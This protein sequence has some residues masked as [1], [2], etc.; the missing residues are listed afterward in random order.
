MQFHCSAGVKLCYNTQK[1]REL[2]AFP[3]S[4][5]KQSRLRSLRRLMWCWAAGSPSSTCGFQTSLDGST[6]AFN[7]RQRRTHTICV[8]LH[9]Q[10]DDAYE[11]THLEK[12]FVS[13]KTLGLLG[14]TRHGGIR[15]LLLLRLC[16][17]G[18]RVHPLYCQY[19][20]F[21]P[22]KCVYLRTCHVRRRSLL[23]FAL[24]WNDALVRRPPR[25]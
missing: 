11:E 19:D 9:H 5:L 16:I 23:Y 18:Y 10:V 1:Q 4:I 22:F 6:A 14:Q 25:L 17:I 3:C 24:P 8:K 2:M 12:Q 21:H 13:Q 20:G 15:R 7:T